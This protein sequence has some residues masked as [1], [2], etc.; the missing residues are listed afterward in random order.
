MTDKPTPSDPN[1]SA[2]ILIV[3]DSPTQQEQLHFILEDS[4]Y[5]V[6]TAN[7]GKEGLQAAQSQEFDLVISDIIMPE[8][9]GYELCK[10]I[11][12]DSKLKTLPVVLLTSLTEPKE[13]I[14]ALESGATNFIRKPY[15]AVPLVERI[16]NV[17]ATAKLRRETGS[18]IGLTISFNN[19]KYRFNQDRLQI[20]DMLLATYEDAI[21]QV[22]PSEGATSTSIEGTILV[23]EDSITQMENICFILKEL[24]C[25]VFTA[26]NGLEALRTLEST[27]VDLVISDII[28]PEMDGY[29]LCKT[30]RADNRFGG[31]PI[32]LLTSRTK[33]E[34][35]IAGLEAGA[36]N[37]ICKPF[38]NSYLEARV[39][40][41]LSNKSIYVDNQN[42]SKIDVVFA[43]QQFAITADRNQILDL[44][45]SSYDSAVQH[46]Q[47]LALARD[48]LSSINEELEER[49]A[50]RTEELT[51]EIEE[52][53]KAELA[54]QEQRDFAESLL[55]TAQA[56]IL[57]LDNKGRIVRFNPYLE[58]LTGYTLEEVI[59]KDWI[60]TFIPE[61]EHET[62]RALLTRAIDNQPT[63]GNV[64]LITTKD[65]NEIYVEWY[66]KTL[67]EKDDNVVGLLAI[68]QNVS[69]RKLSEEIARIRLEL[70]EYS[71]SHSLDTLLQ[72]TL[73]EICDLVKSPIGFYHFISDDQKTIVQ[74]QWSTRTVNEFCNVR[75]KNLHYRL[76]D[77]GVWADCIRQKKAVIHNDYDSLDYKNGLPNGHTHVNRELVYPII[78]KNK[79]V[80][81]IGVG[82]KPD[83]YEE[84]DVKIV[85]NLADIT[86]EI[87]NR[88]RTDEQTKRLEEQLQQSQKMES[89]GRLAGGVAH[90][91]NNLITAI[92]GFSE[93]V[94]DSLNEKDPIRQDV[95]EIQKAADSA[96]LL[97]NQ[98]L[99][100]SR[101]QVVSPQAIN[102]N[103]SI[104]FSEKMLERIIGE[105][106]DL[107]FLPE[108]NI[109]PVL[110]DPGQVNQ[111]LVNLAVNS[112]D[113]MLSGGKLT[114]ETKNVVLD[115]KRCQT[116]NGQISGDYVMLA[117]SDDGSGMTNET[118]T[119]IFEPFFTTKE[120]GKGTGLGLSTVH[121]IM[122]Q[123]KG[124]INIYSEPGHGTTFKMY[125]PAIAQRP[126]DVR[127]T[128]D[129]QNLEGLETILVVED[130][131]IVRK[132]V[133]RSL[134]QYGYKIIEAKNGGEALNK[135]DDA[136]IQIDLL[137]TD[138]VMP[139]MG[140]KELYDKMLTFNP[141]LKAVF[142]SGYTEN[143]IAHHGVLDKGVNFI[144]KPF[145]QK[146]LVQKVRQVLD[147]SRK[148]IQEDEMK[149]V[150]V[151]DDDEQIVELYK[152]YARKHK[153]K[154]FTALNGKKGLDIF[155]RHEKEVGLVLCD[156]N[157]NNTNGEALVEKMIQFNEDCH[158]LIVSGAVP[159]GLGEKYAANKRISILQKATRDLEKWFMDTIREYYR[160]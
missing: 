61:R 103:N 112:R 6:V 75:E 142:M 76:E 4:G 74:Q 40:N 98:L 87:I 128:N 157:L 66:D 7:N 47:E 37:F 99:A 106:I 84:K 153:F 79:V 62:V 95:E 146:K 43:G 111:I 60:E 78:R 127:E 45:V 32:I 154:L 129:P 141:N 42:T 1:E 70:L 101:K 64:N 21:Y 16:R 10:A 156:L 89:I 73:D 14:R 22:Q 108:K 92:Q 131:E 139:V 3:E 9:D 31:V 52:R 110:M 151:I 104:S 68:G 83:D 77:A 148:S 67:K 133:V 159:A 41:L 122:H 17:I 137:L 158:F 88:K 34:D 126:V 54:L 136:K 117:I 44:L 155:A 36:S 102:L 18:E 132:L 160:K 134:R 118:I 20:L 138:V 58:E 114:I 2:K 39:R 97:T 85:A 140:G 23:V 56:I 11:R 107:V 65:G 71:V 119:K 86:W 30:I 124:H 63:R 80:A 135:L 123:N 5:D 69:D 115:M 120:K 94:K 50:E 38:Q 28:M 116:C 48:E 19:K 145:I 15:E 35:L 149:G 96:A 82:N 27:P 150:L 49:V 51:D 53:K 25:K 144:Q 100:F 143:A 46:S 8:M 91:F 113:A 72:K 33:P 90:D 130:Q 55:E 152:I 147:Q 125:F 29:E 105:D 13:V 26:T 12:R 121:G 93:L 109:E 57:V 24:G 59:G 81:I